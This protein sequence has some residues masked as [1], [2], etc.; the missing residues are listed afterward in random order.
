M[1]EEVADEA[2][3]ALI[4]V[5]EVGEELSIVS[6]EKKKWSDADLKSGIGRKREAS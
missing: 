3:G 2:L 6:A 5:L 1:V 4:Q